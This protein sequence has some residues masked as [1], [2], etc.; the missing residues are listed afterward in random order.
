MLS[1]DVVVD[2]FL[3]LGNDCND[4]GGGCLD[5]DDNGVLHKRQRWPSSSSTNTP[6][7]T[8]MISLHVMHLCCLHSSWVGNLH[9]FSPTTQMPD[10][11][12]NIVKIQ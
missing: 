6:H 7:I 3:V 2:G 10:F 8:C 4:G 1:F 11:R 9:N 12:S 5:D